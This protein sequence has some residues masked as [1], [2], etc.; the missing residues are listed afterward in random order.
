[1]EK[2]TLLIK[3]TYHDDS[4]GSISVEA[5]ICQS[6]ESAKAEILAEAN[7]GF[8]TDCKSLAELSNL[9]DGDIEEAGSKEADEGCP[10]E[11]YWYDNGK[12]EE[13][14]ISEV[15]NDGKYHEL[16][17]GEVEV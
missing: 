11:F 12:G 3:R 8:E 7:K 10:F 4:E 9:L 15:E 1:M 17:I 14:T 16:I 13:Y 5:K 2:V 6:A